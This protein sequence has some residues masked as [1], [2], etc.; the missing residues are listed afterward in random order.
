LTVFP[1]SGRVVP[2]VGA[3]TVRELIYGAYRVFYRV[4]SAVEILSVRH[5]SQLVRPEEVNE[6]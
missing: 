1:Q 3:R 2:E 4:G 6:N 5:D